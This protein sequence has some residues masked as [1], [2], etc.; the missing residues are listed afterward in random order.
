LGALKWTKPPFKPD[1]GYASHSRPETW[2][3]FD[4]ALNAYK[5]GGFDGI[6]FVLTED[7]PYAAIDLDK[8]HDAESGV[9]E[10]WARDI[11]QAIPSYWEL[12]PS[13]TGLR[14]IVRAKLPPGGR[15]KQQ[16]EMYD[17]LRYVTITG[18]KIE[19]EL[20]A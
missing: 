14:A 3:S 17:S 12:S 20:L 5:R 18:H 1:G 19:R 4:K 15:K 16:L 10:D 11:V 13:G 6:G 9:T 7:D 8:C 2:T